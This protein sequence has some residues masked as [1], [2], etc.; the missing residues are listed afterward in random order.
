MT[1]PKPSISSLRP[2]I[3][4][5]N[6]RVT[7]EMVVENLPATVSNVMFTM[8]DPSDPPPT[9]PPKP[10]PNAP[11]PYPNIELSIL[12]SRRQQVAMLFIVE[13]KETHTS[14]TLHIPAP[15]K[16]E[17]YTARAE[18]THQDQILDVVEVPFTLN[19]KDANNE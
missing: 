9:S 17:Q 14:L 7:F 1:D 3:L 18:M 13:H 2:I 12:N 11:S 16:Q 6:R 19:Q 5:D 10:D 8:P 15:D 4:E